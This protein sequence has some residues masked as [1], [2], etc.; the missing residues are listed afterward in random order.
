MASTIFMVCKGYIKNTNYK[1]FNFNELHL[2]ALAGFQPNHCCKIS[3][4]FRTNLK[5]NGM[6][7]DTIHLS[8]IQF[9][10]S[11]TEQR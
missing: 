2:N 1:R 8:L 11:E 9:L 4:N 10:P 7:R 5:R 6:A 3:R